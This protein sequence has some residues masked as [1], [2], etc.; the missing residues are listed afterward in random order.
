MASQRQSPERLK[1]VANQEQGGRAEWYIHPQPKVSKVTC[2]QEIQSELISDL[3]KWLYS[4]LYV[5]SRTNHGLL[6]PC[7]SLCPLVYFYRLQK[8]ITWRS[9]LWRLPLW[10]LVKPS[11]LLPFST[12]SCKA[13][14]TSSRCPFGLGRISQRHCIDHFVH[15]SYMYTKV[16]FYYI[17]KFDN[18]IIT[19]GGFVTT[20]SF[21][22]QRYER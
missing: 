10:R 1:V 19:C 22:F 7:W 3:R 20:E 6:R 15:L 18:Y 5:S 17:L 2:H 21:I 14:L 11:S 4:Q 8:L 12:F 9:K 13:P 16:I